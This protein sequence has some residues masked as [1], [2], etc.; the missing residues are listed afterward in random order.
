MHKKLVWVDCE[1]T[2]LD[3]DKDCIIEI[4]SIVTDSDLQILEEGP[5][6]V[7]H[8]EERA[9]NNLNPWVQK[10]HSESGLLDK[11]R[12]SSLSLAEA[13]KQTLAF[14][15]KHV[16]K[17][18]APLCGNSIGTDRAFLRRGMPNLES[19]LHYRNVDVST[20]KILYHNWMP[21]A[22]SFAKQGQHRALDDIK[23]SIAELAYYRSC[24]FSL[25]EASD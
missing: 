3:V 4:A 12:Q 17:G 18:E 22:K 5:N 20:I 15:Q 13:E 8:A 6:L 21:D 24:F 23:E 14:I 7:I 2:G 9:L 19:F 10:T 1:M 11:V 25:P 16:G